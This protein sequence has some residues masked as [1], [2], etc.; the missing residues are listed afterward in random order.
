[1]NQRA[2]AKVSLVNGVIDAPCHMDTGARKNGWGWRDSHCYI[3]E[4]KT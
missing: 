2:L 4:G 1:M 3:T